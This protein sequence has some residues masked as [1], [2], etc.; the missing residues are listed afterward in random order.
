[1]KA[2]ALAEPEPRSVAAYDSV[3]SRIKLP[4]LFHAR[5][6]I[7][8]GTV[9][10]VAANH[11][12]PERHTAESGWA[13]GAYRNRTQTHFARITDGNTVRLTGR[14]ASSVRQMA[15]RGGHAG[16]GRLPKIRAWPR[17]RKESR[18]RLLRRR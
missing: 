5:V 7:L 6:C 16:C 9:R 11:H 17:I 3:K 8:G 1:M 2:V 12:R 14:G 18:L 4:L 10:C 13:Q 15:A